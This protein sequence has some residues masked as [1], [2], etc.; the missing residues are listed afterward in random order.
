[1]LACVFAV[2][3]AEAKVKVEALEQLIAEVVAFD[4]SEVL[5]LRVTDNEFDA[6]KGEK[7]KFSSH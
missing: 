5:D 2:G 6:G 3:N 1:M 7:R 4:H